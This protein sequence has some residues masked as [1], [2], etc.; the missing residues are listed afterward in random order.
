MDIK[1][2]VKKIIFY[3]VLTVVVV[4]TASIL[5]TYLY[6]DRLIDHFIREAN[7]SLNTPVHVDKISVSSLKNFPSISLTFDG[8]YIEES[9]DKSSAPLLQAEKIDF[10]FN[11]IAVFRKNY[12]VEKVFIKKGFFH[13]KMDKNGNINYD[14]FKQPDTTAT[15]QT[16][17]VDLSKIVLE[18][19]TFKYQNQ[20]RNVD[21]DFTTPSLTARLNAVGRVY[22]I[23]AEGKVAVNHVSVNNTVW[24][25]NKQTQVEADLKYNDELKDLLIRPSVITVNSSDF[26]VEG[27]YQ[28]LEK[29][30]ISLNVDGKDTDIQTLLSILPHTMVQD[31]DKYQSKGEV[32]FSMIL[33]GEIGEKTSP[34]MTINFGLNDSELYHPDTRVKVTHAVLRGTFIATDLNNINNSV[35][36]LKDINGVVEDHNFKA[37]LYLKNFNTPYVK[38]NFEGKLDLE[39]VFKFYKSESVQAGSGQLDAHLNFEGQVK[40]L[41]KK[42]SSGRFKTT[43]D[44]NL[45]ALTL[46]LSH[47]PLKL[48]NVSG[49]LLFNNNDLALSDVS[50]K[51]G[52]SDFL[53]NGFFKNIIAYLLF[54]NEPVGIESDLRS[55]FI[56][57]DELLAANPGEE[58]DSKYKFTISPKL[59]LKFDCD[60]DQLKFRRFNPTNIKGDL[61]VRNEVAQSNRIQFNAMGGS[62]TLDGKVDA[63]Y[64]KLLRVNTSFALDNIDVD[65]I[66]YV[67][68]NFNQDFLQDKHLKGKIKADVQASM[69]FSD[70]LHLYPGSLVSN[71]STTIIGGQLNNFEPMQRLSKYLDEDKLDHLIFSELRNDIHIENKKIYLPQMEVSTNVTDIKIS[72]IHTFDQNIDY[73]VIAP[74]RSKKKIDRDEAFG[75]IEEDDSGRTMLYLKII[76]NTSD[77]LVLYDK[78]SVKKKIVSDIKK[79]AKELKDAFKNKGKEE[80]PEIELEEDDYFDWGDD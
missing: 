77:Y 44:I 62:I 20:L 60:V 69:T 80:T 51:L 52:N 43:G 76:G 36:D 66:F 79:E 3:L 78:E 15:T 5:A 25:E 49:N 6:R 67:F 13:L 17:K 68:E 50:G 31:F 61:I 57:L 37:N 42:A 47:Y 53:L 63:S 28:F 56:D 19:T 35:L 46:K 30:L 70:N 41:Q 14:I 1:R 65:S 2:V 11:P 4:V 24:A 18:E 75:A 10:T 40:D 45:D 21:L 73:R 29:Q 23:L 38:G 8:V 26:A 58:S 74:L 33:D 27:T 55:K 7:K 59:V 9:F 34:K 32:Y 71:I 39:S 72:G 22:D 64:D 54:E 16:V 12:T 48:D